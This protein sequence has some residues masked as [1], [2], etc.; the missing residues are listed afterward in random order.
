MIAGELEIKL[1]ANIAQLQTSMNKAEKSVDSAMRNIDKSVAL[2][3]KAFRGL[4]A[5]MSVTA[6]AKYAD[7]FKRFDSQLKL[8]TKSVER[9]NTAYADV[10]R[11]ARESQSDIGAIGVLYARLTNNLR[12]F[13][14]AQKDIGTITESVALSLRVSNATVQETNSVMLQL[15]QSFGSGKLN[16]QEFLAVSEGAPIIMRQVAKSIGVTYGELKNLSSEGKITAEVLKTA[17]SDPEYLAGLKVAVKEVGTISSAMTVFKNNITTFIGEADK[18]N[19]ASSLLAKGI[20]ALAD[21]L[22]ILTTVAFAGAII[23]AGKFVGAKMALL[24]TMLNEYKANQAL[25]AQEAMAL[26][27]RMAH[28]QAVLADIAAVNTSTV[29]FANNAA[30]VTMNTK[31][32]MAADAAQK[33][34]AASTATA[35]VA[36]KASGGLIAALGGPIG[37]IITA[38]GL[39]AI[40]YQTFA[41]K[42][43]E[44]I[45]RIYKKERELQ[46]I[47]EKAPEEIA[48]QAKSDLELINLDRERIVKDLESAKKA[49]KRAKDISDVNGTNLQALADY[50]K[51]QQKVLKLE[52]LLL[53]NVQS[54]KR[55]SM[56]K[57]LAEEQSAMSIDESMKAE[58]RLREANVKVMSEEVAAQR[59]IIADAKLANFDPAS[60]AKIIADAEKKIRDLT[61]ATKTLKEENKRLKELRK[62][63]ADAN[64]KL[65]STY[66]DLRKA[67][68]DLVKA[69]IPAYEALQRRLDL[70]LDSTAAD[71]GLIQSRI[72]LAKA[73][74][75]FAESVRQA[76]EVMDATQ[77]FDDMQ[78][79]KVDSVA[80]A[81]NKIKQQTEDLNISMIK[82]DKERAYAQLQ[83]EHQR[84]V[85]IIAMR[86]AE[87]EDKDKLLEAENERYATAMEAQARQLVVNKNIARELGMTFQSAFE[88][89]IVGGKKLSEVLNGL[90]QDMLKLVTRKMITE[91][92]L[93][94]IAGPLQSLIPSFGG[95]GGVSSSAGAYSIDNNPYINGTFANG[96]IMSS[97]GSLP[98]NKYAK[99]GI[100][101][102]PQ[103]A[104]FG[105]GRMNEAYVPLPD[106]RSI[107]VSMNGGS[108]VSV[109]INNNSSAQASAQE[110][111]DAR[112][113]RRIEVT[114]GD[115]VASEIRRNGS[116]AYQS[117][118]NTFTTR[119]KLVGR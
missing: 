85:E 112:G 42:S 14:T 75:D 39:A 28:T 103:L 71:R 54:F 4:G 43:I 27:G 74:Y 13:G 49:E 111:T 83:I 73:E 52:E 91:P 61:D 32:I 5:F 40:A 1:F 46:K 68:E 36:T 57:Q 97:G 33:S 51:A 59:Q 84:N 86:E 76:N 30:A 8:A 53:T 65:L 58:K 79:A 48:K 67:S 55:A 16:G 95:G 114:I 82:S 78:Q 41:D 24:A 66:S 45:D 113:N 18:A 99:G 20:V 100:A 80:D 88:D 22:N 98:L 62:E 12:E 31:A 25:I 101:T 72:D 10:Q 105:E 21:N 81:Y 34:Y 19:G 108:E 38:L 29:S 106:G 69:D 2:A 92:L 11:I 118:R 7:E 90:A 56:D 93:D 102:G 115:M 17:L 47:R 89:A 104:L 70:T 44:Q 37:A 26:K 9:Y 87:Q 96:G 63:E 109:V 77:E 23:A 15:S 116:D 64:K 6:L 3:N 107:P 35:N 117:I 50:E 119:P 60:R 94:A 110:T